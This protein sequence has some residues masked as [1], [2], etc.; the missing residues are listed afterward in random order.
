LI[1]CEGKNIY[2]MSKSSKNRRFLKISIIL[3][4]L[5]AL[6]SY[7][8]K[9]ISGQLKHE[10]ENACKPIKL[11]SKE[12]NFIKKHV[13]YFASTKTWPPMNME[14]NG[15]IAGISID[16]WNDIKKRLGLKSKIIIINNWSK[17][18]EALKNKKVDIVVSSEKTKE[19]EKYAIFSKPYAT[20]SIV[21]ATRNDV[22]F[23]PSIYYLKGKKIAIGKNYTVDMLLKRKYPFLKIIEVKNIKNALSLLSRGKVYAVVDILPVIAYQINKCNFA[24]LKISGKIDEVYN[25]RIMVRKDYKMLIPAINKAIDSITNKDKE[26]FFSKWIAVHVQDGYELKYILTLSSIMILFIIIIIAWVVYLKK[27]IKKRNILEEQLERLATMDKLTSIYNRYKMDLSLEEQIEI[28]KRYNRSLGLIFLDIDFFK[29]I[30]D[31]YGHKAGDT[32]LVE[33]SKLVLQTIRKSDIF[34]R[35]GGEEFLIILPETEKKEAIK[36]AEKLRKKIENYKFDKIDKTIT[37]SFGVTSFIENDDI[38]KIM[39]RADKKLYKAKQNGRNKV[40]TD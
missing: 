3:I 22:G 23:I 31:T 24:N 14:E 35:W 19:R 5:L 11:S 10:K 26:R 4:L 15:K 37:C 32:V 21:I 25:A 13:F 20:F 9:N 17:V 18:L 16:F 30:N 12:N 34:G 7:A 8:A 39:I 28:V 27:E 38:E 33:L 40:E 1:A 6:F 2:K 36:L 29:N